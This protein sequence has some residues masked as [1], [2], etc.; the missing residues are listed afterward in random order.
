MIHGSLGYLF[1]QMV[2]NKLRDKHLFLR[3]L[4]QLRNLLLLRFLPRIPPLRDRSAY[5]QN[6]QNEIVG[7]DIHDVVA[8]YSPIASREKTFLVSKHLD[9]NSYF[10]EGVLS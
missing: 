9:P 1:W 2:R 7:D 3:H 10:S 6:D 8:A 5:N 4:L